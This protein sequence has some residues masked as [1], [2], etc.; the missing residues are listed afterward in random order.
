M[1]IQHRYERQF[2]VYS[3]EMF[4]NIRIVGFGVVLGEKVIGKAIGQFGKQLE[5]LADCDGEF[6]IAGISEVAKL[7]EIVEVELIQNFPWVFKSRGRG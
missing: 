1:I 5:I 3:G 2:R 6:Y 7:I 4:T